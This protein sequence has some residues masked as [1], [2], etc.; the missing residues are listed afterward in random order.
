MKKLELILDQETAFQPL[1]KVLRNSLGLSKKQ[2]SQAKFRENGIC[3]NGKKQRVSYVG[4][5]GEI[6]TVCLEESSEN[7]GKVFP[8]EGKL[9]IL[10]EDPDILAA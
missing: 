1:E 3:I 9:E 8:T 5:P 6:L 7:T 10:Y 2:I 4:M